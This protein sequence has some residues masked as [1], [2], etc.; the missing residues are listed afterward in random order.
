[1]ATFEEIKSTLGE[2]FRVQ[3]N[4]NGNIKVDLVALTQKGHTLCMVQKV[5]LFQE[6]QTKLNSLGFD[7]KDADIREGYFNRSDNWQNWPHIWFSP[8]KAEQTVATPDVG[9]IATELL[10]Q[11][12]AMSGDGATQK[13]T[14]LVKAAT[15]AEATVVEAEEPA[16]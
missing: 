8:P 13:V 11:L 4:R 2:K 16:F 6:A 3:Q 7:I 12:M 1:M 5:K 15:A 10:K 9:A 14:E